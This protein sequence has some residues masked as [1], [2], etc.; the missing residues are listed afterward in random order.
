MFP[1]NYFQKFFLEETITIEELSKNHIILSLG[2]KF[3]SWCTTV[4]RELGVLQK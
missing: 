4:M 1:K 3:T 2:G